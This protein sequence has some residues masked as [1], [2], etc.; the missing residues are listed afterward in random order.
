MYI[1]DLEEEVKRLHQKYYECVTAYTPRGEL[2]DFS[3]YELLIHTV[4][5]KLMTG[6]DHRL[7]DDEASYGD[8]PHSLYVFEVMME[9]VF[10]EE[11]TPGD[12]TVGLTAALLHDIGYA[13]MAEGGH[14]VSR[15]FQ[16]AGMRIGHMKAGAAHVKELLRKPKFE[17]YYTDDQIQ[18]IAGIIEVHDNPSVS[19]EKEGIIHKGIPLDIT[20]NLL[21]MHREADR[22][23]MSSKEGFDNDFRGRLEQGE[24][25]PEE[26][27]KWVVT[28]HMQE[29]ELYQD[30]GNF[31][32]G[33]LFRTPK[34]YSIFLQNVQAIIK[35]YN[36]RVPPQ[37][38]HLF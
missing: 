2:L 6:R 17:P 15:D 36:I 30:D 12:I 21:Y 8:L 26:H 32:E 5:D 19:Y 23:W 31:I 11:C 10:S 28:R 24:T 20:D 13:V 7:R 16:K 38:S 14:D 27:L 3:V 29:K 1:F 18:R 22:M 9:I 34:A 37:I 25:T 33:F 4:T 35:R